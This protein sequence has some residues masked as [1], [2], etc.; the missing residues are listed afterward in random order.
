MQCHNMRIAAL[1]LVGGL[2]T[3]R[4]LMHRRQESKPC[5][6]RS[7]QDDKM[8]FRERYTNDMFW[9]VDARLRYAHNAAQTTNGTNLPMC[10]VR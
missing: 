7:Q 5:F 8:A 1:S 4:R 2:R 6:R 10:G 3:V 9:T